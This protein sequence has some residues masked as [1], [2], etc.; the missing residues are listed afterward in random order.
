MSKLL[1]VLSAVAMTRIAS[2]QEAPEQPQSPPPP[3]LEAA[4]S[5]P[6]AP[7]PEPSPYEKCLA[8]RRS[9]AGDAEQATDLKERARLLQSMPECSPSMTSEPPAP[10]EPAATTTSS[11][12]GFALEVRLDTSQT[13]VDSD[14]V[15]PGTQGGIFIGTRSRSLMIGI[16]LDLTRLTSTQTAGTNIDVTRSQTSVLVSPGIRAVLARSGDER[17]ELFGQ[18][19]I[20]YGRLWSSESGSTVDAPSTNHLRAQVAPGIRYWVSPNFAVGGSAG[21]R[22]DRYSRDIMD[23]T[24]SAGM[25]S[26]F[27]SLQLTGVF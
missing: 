25:T 14:L 15:L 4:E 10:Q 7:A 16:G 24:S 6:P 23:A 3:P 5:P 22:Y 12:G 19:D 8:Q 17:T 13:P 20:G 11:Q 27:S 21:F 9:I 18:L 26:V 1:I 2:A